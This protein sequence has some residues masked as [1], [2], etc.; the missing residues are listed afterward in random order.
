[1]QKR[2]LLTGHNSTAISDY[3]QR[4]P[5]T[6]RITKCSPFK[7]SLKTSY[8]L[9]MLRAIKVQLEGIFDVTIVTNGRNALQYLSSHHVD[10]ILLDYVM[11]GEDGTVVLQ[12][13]RCI[14]EFLTI[15]VLF[16][17]GVSDEQ[18]VKKGL[19]LN[20]QGYLLKPVSREVLIEAINTT[21]KN[22]ALIK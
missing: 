11:P 19:E 5:S 12:A 3:F 22:G 18:K 4:N 10:I 6:Y 7:D 8:D 2:I 21:L 16:L 17:T 9:R 15:P 1:M 14:P 13:I 20:P